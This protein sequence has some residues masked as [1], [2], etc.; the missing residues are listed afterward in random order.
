M[1][2]RRWSGLAGAPT[3]AWLTAIEAGEALGPVVEPP[4]PEGV[5]SLRRLAG[6]GGTPRREVRC[7]PPAARFRRRMNPT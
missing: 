6:R 4:R 2:L 5:D 7:R 1:I 3:S